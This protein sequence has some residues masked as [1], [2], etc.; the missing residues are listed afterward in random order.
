[1]VTTQQTPG[2]IGRKV[3]MMTVFDASG[4]A[5]GVTVIE[6]TGNRITQIRTQDRD[7]YQ[8][9]QVGAPGKRHRINKPESGHLRKSEAESLS[10]LR[11]FRVLESD[12]FEVGQ[13]IGADQFEP[14][15][16]VNVTGTTKGRGFA[17]GVRRW[18]F[19]GGPKTHGQSDRHR[20]PGSIGA[21]TTPGRVW[22]G[23]KMAGH[24]GNRR[25]TSLNLLVVY[26]DPARQLIFVQ[27]AV[28]GPRNGTV[29][30]AHGRRNPL[31]DY[32]PPI[33]DLDQLEEADIQSDTPID[34][35]DTSEET[36]V[37]EKVDDDTS[38]ETS[39][40]SDTEDDV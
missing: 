28:P 16:F 39:N 24:M 9:V 30:I 29:I 5:R 21:G 11:E 27:G 14:G 40:P 7:G 31:S 13:A 33:F 12:S 26:S 38:E 18:N 2:L 22:K 20:A 36:V 6:V 15:T 23:Q 34:E 32:A 37:A 25:R 8:A 19:R 1:M 17:G 3:G 10:E 4:R 35:G